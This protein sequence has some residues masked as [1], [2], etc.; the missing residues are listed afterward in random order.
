VTG[1]PLRIVDPIPRALAHYERELR[2]V[3]AACGV[4]AEGVGSPSIERSPTR[5]SVASRAAAV[6]WW[7]LRSRGAS[8]DTLVVFPAF[9]LADPATWVGRRDR[10]WLVVHDPAAVAKQFGMGRFAARLGRAAVGRRVRVLVHSQPAADVLRDRGWSVELLPHP[11]RQPHADV[12]TAARRRTGP[13]TVLGQWKPA[14]SIEPLRQ[15]SAAAAWDGRRQVVGRGWPAVPGWT[16]D[17]RFVDE[18]E[19]DDRIAA[20]ACVLLPYDHY[21]QSGIAVRCLEAGLPV[22]GLRH[23][24]LEGLFGASWPGLVDD[25]DWVA[26]TERVATVAAEEMVDRRSDYWQRCVAAWESSS[27]VSSLRG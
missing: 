11:V 15:F 18:A 4:D 14:R 22:V 20:A 26:A 21:F 8:G 7:R 24:F 13:V 3:L 16:V 25:D 27:L 6:L 1:L 17:S 2:E 10:I 23:A 19:L 12:A 9:G 5:A